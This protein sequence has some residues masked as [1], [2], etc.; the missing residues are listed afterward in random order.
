MNQMLKD[1]F[2]FPQPEPQPE[3]VLEDAK[4]AAAVAQR[5]RLAAMEAQEAAEPE[6]QP[7][8]VVEGRKKKGKPRHRKPRGLAVE[9]ALSRTVIMVAGERRHLKPCAASGV[10]CRGVLVGLLIA[11]A[12]VDCALNCGCHGRA[13]DNHEWVVGPQLSEMRAPRY[14]VKVPPIA[15]VPRQWTM[16][17]SAPHML[18]AYPAVSRHITAYP[19]LQ[20]RA[21][22]PGA[23]THWALPG[24]SLATDA[25][26]QAALPR[27]GF[28]HTVDLDGLLY[29]GARGWL[30]PCG[31]LWLR[32]RPRRESGQR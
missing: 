15:D 21:H 10:A 13:L 16:P 14:V 28:T 2:I 19:P 30:A 18:W 12:V 4:E 23:S 7:E 22:L 9:L 27:F 11:H 31:R 6:P 24:W 3:P 17:T 32:C 1:E 20:F 26:L 25:L 5:Q 8:P 29:R